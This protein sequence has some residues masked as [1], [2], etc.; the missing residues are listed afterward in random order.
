[1]LA[2]VVFM[3]A[4]VCS[5]GFMAWL[6]FF[7]LNRGINTTLEMRKER[8]RITRNYLIFG[9]IL[10]IAA[11]ALSAAFVQMASPL[12]APELGPGMP[13]TVAP[14]PP[15]TSM[16]KTLVA[17]GMVL[18][19]VAF[20]L[21]LGAF[22]L[23][24]SFSASMRPAGAQRHGPIGQLCFGALLLGITVA[25]VVAYVQPEAL[26]PTSDLVSENGPTKSR[27]VPIEQAEAAK[28]AVEQA[29]GL[30]APPPTPEA[31]ATE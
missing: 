18:S 7:I 15:T 10:L 1:M 30:V 11:V 6:V 8:H 3:G 27:P 25:L 22:A 9:A 12:P 24:R 28:S 31:T 19:A 16:H 13:Q 21:W 26:A 4:V 23:N 29:S 17:G 5:A 2:S 20:L 14:A